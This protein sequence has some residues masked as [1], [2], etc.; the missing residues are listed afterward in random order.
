[1]HNANFCL[2]L[3]DY[4]QDAWLDSLAMDPT[5]ADRVS[6]I[7]NNDDEE[8][9]LSS[10]DVGKIKRRIA[11]VLEPG[12]TVLYS[13]L[14]HCYLCAFYLFPCPCLPCFIKAY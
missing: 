10:D 8:Q 11:S 5:L 7:P 12:E 13:S 9:E 4:L 2:C 3:D 6:T 14:Y 1:M